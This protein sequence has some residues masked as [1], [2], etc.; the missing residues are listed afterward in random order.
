MN[1]I[2]I[3][4]EFE[5]ILDEL[6]S[7]SLLIKRCLWLFYYYV[8]YKVWNK[9]WITNKKKE[10]N[11]QWIMCDSMKN[12]NTSDLWQLN[13]VWNFFMIIK[14]CKEEFGTFMNEHMNIYE[15]VTNGSVIKKQI[16]WYSS[17]SFI[18]KYSFNR[19]FQS[20]SKLQI[21]SVYCVTSIK[22]KVMLGP[23]RNLHL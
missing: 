7:F 21:L 16:L 19:L 10:S 20:C 13:H 17:I 11:E 15:F 3:L 22:I 9:R 5:N 14:I 8:K 6:S 18:C 4:N 1:L 23:L 2:L 12:C